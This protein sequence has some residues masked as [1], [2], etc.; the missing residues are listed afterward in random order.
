LSNAAGINKVARLDNVARVQ[1]Q[2]VVLGQTV[3]DFH[4]PG[5]DG[6]SDDSVMGGIQVGYNWQFGHFVFGVEG[7][8]SGMTADGHSPY[9]TS[10]ITTID[11]FENETASADLTTYRK[12]ETNWTASGRAR[13]GWAN[14]RLMLYATGGVALADVTVRSI[15]NSQTVFFFD[16]VVPGLVLP[17]DT[18]FDGV[19]IAR[20]ADHED[21][22]QVGWTAGG[23]A[24]WAAKDTVSFALEYRHN[25]FGD[26][27][28]HLDNVHHGAL[29]PGGTGLDYDSDQMTLRVNILLGHLG[30]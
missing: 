8:W 10:S 23:G 4:T 13:V 12:A 5:L 11:F 24:E 25:D 18:I 17:P 14:G 21:N 30:K 3:L 29:T 22:L 15:D 7:D 1:D 27:H 19:A 6:T 16:E 26:D 2:Q 20:N 28:Y 9:F